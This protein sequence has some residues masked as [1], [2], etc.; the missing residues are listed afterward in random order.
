MHKAS[1]WTVYLTVQIRKTHAL[2]LIPAG[3]A[4]D[5]HAPA[6]AAAHAE[7]SRGERKNASKGTCVFQS[8]LVPPLAPAGGGNTCVSIRLCERVCLWETFLSV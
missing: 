1:L 2:R 3:C 6:R 8:P 5:S 7:G 4:H